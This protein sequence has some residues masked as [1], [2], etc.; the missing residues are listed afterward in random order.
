[1]GGGACQPPSTQVQGL[2]T[3]DLGGAGGSSQARTWAMV[4]GQSLSLKVASCL[5]VLLCCLQGGPFQLEPWP[6]G[7]GCYPL[8]LTCSGKLGL[9]P[10]ASLLQGLGTQDLGGAGES[11]MEQVLHWPLSWWKPQICQLEGSTA[12]V[13]RCAYRPLTVGVDLVFLHSCSP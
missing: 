11:Q 7:Q 10:P 1:M 3:Q 8:I 13:G 6:R 9:L 4:L 5:G 12:V 2:G